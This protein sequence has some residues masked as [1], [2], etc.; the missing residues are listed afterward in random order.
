MDRWVQRAL[1]ALGSGGMMLVL[2]SCAAT[3][4]YPY[5]LYRQQH[6]IEAEDVFDRSETQLETQPLEERARY[7]L[8]RGMTLLALG[9]V[10]RAQQWLGYA[11][12]LQ[13]RQP[14]VLTS[15][16]RHLLQL[17]WQKLDESL[18]RIATAAAAAEGKRANPEQAS[19]PT[20]E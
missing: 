16:D 5:D 1:G 20:N 9:D 18:R 13:R 15:D 19:L 7:G 10:E 8:Y 6:Y 17:G 11:T 4:S 2:C 14:A 3:Q 12:D